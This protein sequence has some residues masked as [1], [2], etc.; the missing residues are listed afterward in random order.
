MQ[1]SEIAQ[2]TLVWLP[3]FTVE[4]KQWVKV[5]NHNLMR[6]Q[7]F[8]SSLF[9]YIS[10]ITH[11]ASTVNL[12]LIMSHWYCPN[13]ETVIN[14]PHCIPMCIVA[15]QGSTL[16]GEESVLNCEGCWFISKWHH[17]VVLIKRRCSYF[18][19]AIYFVGHFSLK[20]Q[21]IWYYKIR[22]LCKIYIPIKPA[23]HF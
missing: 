10:P 8:I 13:Y 6:L 19:N 17:F 5:G 9:N 12:L 18:V 4:P 1:I 3:T 23:S 2:T 22:L 7:P 21:S 11:N 15:P 16:R 14:I 20:M